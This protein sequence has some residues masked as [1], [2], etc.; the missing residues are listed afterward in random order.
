MYLLQCQIEEIIMNRITILLLALVCTACQ[1]SGP[2]EVMEKDLNFSSTDDSELFF[3]N[4]RQMYYD[5][6]ELPE[7][8]LNVFRIKERAGE[9]NYPSI[10][11]AI[12]WNWLK[13]EAYILIEPNLVLADEDPI[14]V[15]WSNRDTGETGTYRYD[16]GNNMAQLSFVTKIYNGLMNGLYLEVWA[17][18]RRQSFLEASKDRE[19]FRKTMVDYYRL[20]RTFE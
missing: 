5:L 17:R 18:S 4:V 12:V 15:F 3:K 11:L 7:A 14:V 16:K 6:E 2:K 10:D 9:V 19:A 13:D 8:N 1:I 20:T